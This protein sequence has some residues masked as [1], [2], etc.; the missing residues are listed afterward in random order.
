MRVYRSLEQINADFGPCAL[1]IGNFDGVHTGHR[2]ICRRVVQ[3]ARERGW[4]PAALTFH[5]H[6]LRIVAPHRAPRLL[7]TPEERARLLGEAGIEEVL[8]LP[9]SREFSLLSP[10]EFVRR[11]LVEKLHVKA[12][13]VGDNFR[14]GHKH[15]GDTR[16]LAELGRKYG[17]ETEAVQVVACRN[18][19]V[20]SSE[21]RR[22][23][24]AGNVARA[25]RFLERPYALEG[26]VV[27]GFG[28]GSKQTVPTLNLATDAEVLLA[29]GVY[30]TRTRDLD[31]GREW[32]SV[33]NIGYRPTFGGEALTI[34]TFL[35]VPLEGATPERIRVAFLHRIRE[36]RRFNSAEA[37]KSRILIDV[38]RARTYFRRFDR[39]V[40][41]AAGSATLGP[42]QRF[43]G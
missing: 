21:V 9:F 10:E 33:T 19:F 15:A 26:R 30:I 12:V 6:P 34:E 43:G 5:P 20:S 40:G 23:I 11:I 41:R 3:L 25:A 35:L 42:D 38:A 24:E 17:F 27:K 28:I 8:I 31:D 4:K 29:R 13:L 18:T 7:S 2:Q 1:T 37:L 16:L 32:P 39:W 14:F 22:L 36:E